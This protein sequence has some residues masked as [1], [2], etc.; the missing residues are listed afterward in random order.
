MILNVIVPCLQR[1]ENS[2]HVSGLFK[3]YTWWAEAF[4]TC[5]E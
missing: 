2:G 1:A 3:E 4:S 5:K